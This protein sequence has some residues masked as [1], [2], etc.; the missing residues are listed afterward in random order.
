[1][2]AGRI[3]R[4]VIAGPTA[5]VPLETTSPFVAARL[6]IVLGLIAGT[7]AKW[8]TIRSADRALAARARRQRERIERTLPRTVRY[9]H[10]VASGT[11]DLE[12]LIGRVADRKRAFGETARAFARVR[13][14]ATVTGSVDDAIGL[15][16][17]DTPSRET[18]APFLL[19]LRS[20]ARE[21]PT[22]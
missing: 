22:A 13:S 14:T 11:T 4:S 6:P 20:R 17:R 9:M 21:G 1:M 2:A 8:T 3:P 15:V 16:A 7:A 19:T 12:T 5:L 18:F 10:V